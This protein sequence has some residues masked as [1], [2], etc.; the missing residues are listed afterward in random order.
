MQSVRARYNTASAPFPL[1][2]FLKS[3]LQSIEDLWGTF[4]EPDM[5][6]ETA[7]VNSFWFYDMQGPLLGMK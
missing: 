5:R 6:N 3:V 2:V 4:R 7:T 1:H